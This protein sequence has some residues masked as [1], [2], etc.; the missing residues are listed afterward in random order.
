MPYVGLTIAAPFAGGLYFRHP[1]KRVVLVFT[2]LNAAATLLMVA[3]IVFPAAR[4]DFS[5]EALTSSAP[6][7][8]AETPPASPSSQAPAA[9][10]FLQQLDFSFQD[11]TPPAALLLASRFL[12]GFTQAPLVVYA[13]VWVDEFAPPRKAA[14]WM[15]VTQGAAVVGVTVGGVVI[16]GRERKRKR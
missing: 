3:T 6:P 4:D 11:L 10:S 12:V 8:S 15:G 14:L 5:E 16:E 2:A 13:P 7:P 9:P 1:P